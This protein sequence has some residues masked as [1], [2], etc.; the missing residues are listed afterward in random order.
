MFILATWNG[1]PCEM[2]MRRFDS[3]DE[4]EMAAYTWMI[5]Q[6]IIGPDLPID[7]MLAWWW[8]DGDGGNNEDFSLGCEIRE[9]A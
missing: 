6:G 3:K 8:Q 9:V 4:A 5:E 1:P 2:E 7:D